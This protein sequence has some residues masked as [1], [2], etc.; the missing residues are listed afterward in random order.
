MSSPKT[1]LELVSPNG[2][3]MAAVEQDE[4]CAYFIFLAPG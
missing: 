3:V 1:V 4:S 2:N